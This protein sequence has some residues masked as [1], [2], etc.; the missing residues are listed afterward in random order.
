[1]NTQGIR[2]GRILGIDV[3]ADRSWILVFLLVTWNL[4]GSL[5]AGT[6]GLGVRAERGAGGRR[7]VALL[8]VDSRPRIRARAR[9][10]E[11]RNVGALDHA[12]SLRGRVYDLPPLPWTA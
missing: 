9:G 2:I 7:R 8:C 4:T 3:L 1:M 10:Q 6:S 5:P 11:L 12:L